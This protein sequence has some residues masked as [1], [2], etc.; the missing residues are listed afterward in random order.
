MDSSAYDAK[1]RDVLEKRNYKTLAKDP[2]GQNSRGQNSIDANTTPHQ[3]TTLLWSSL[4]TQV[5]NPAQSHYQLKKC[6]YQRRCILFDADHPTNTRHTTSYVKPFCENNQ[7]L[8]SLPIRESDQLINFDV[9]NIFT[10]ITWDK[11]EIWKLQNFY[12]I[13]QLSGQH[14]IH[15]GGEEEF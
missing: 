5:W 7:G 4:K 13:S 9:N 6:I 2:T 8:F 12:N 14:Q 10:F 15:D 3:N 1:I 11:T